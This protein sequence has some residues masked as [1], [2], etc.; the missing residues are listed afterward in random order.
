MLCSSLVP[1]LCTVNALVS[2]ESFAVYIISPLVHIQFFAVYIISYRWSST[3]ARV[4]KVG[5]N[6]LPVTVAWNLSSGLSHSRSFICVR[7]LRSCLNIMVSFNFSLSKMLK[8]FRA[9]FFRPS[10]IVCEQ[11]F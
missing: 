8:V 11:S 10:V 9:V 3:S 1:V 5:F 7:K 4:D 2:A 6:V